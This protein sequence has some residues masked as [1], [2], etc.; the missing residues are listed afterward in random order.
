MEAEGGETGN[1]QVQSQ[2]APREIGKFPMSPECDCLD[3]IQLPAREEADPRLPGRRAHQVVLFL[4]GARAAVT[5][6]PVVTAALEWALLGGMGRSLGY[7]CSVGVK[8]SVRWGGAEGFAV[9]EELRKACCWEIM[10][11]P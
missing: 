6:P 7:V 1:T 2:P 10:L 8:V 5:G 3:L 4:S 9:A 11:M